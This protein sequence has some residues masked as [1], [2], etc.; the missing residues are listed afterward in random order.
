LRQSTQGILDG[1]QRRTAERQ[2]AGLPAIEGGIPFAI[3][4]PESFDLDELV[5]RFKLEVVSE[6]DVTAEGAHRY[7]LVA[8]QRIEDSSLLRLIDEFAQG[9]RGSAAVASMLEIIGSP[10]DPRRLD[11]ILGA[12]LAARWPFPASEEF[13]L[14]A[15]FQTRGMFVDLGE[16]P[17]KARAET[18]DQHD[19]RLGQWFEVQKNRCL[20]K[21]DDFTLQLEDELGR[22]VSA[23]GGEI[24]KQWENGAITATEAKVTF[25]DSISVRIRMSGQ[26]FCDLILNHPRIFEVREPDEVEPPKVHTETTGAGANDFR[27]LPPADRAPSVC[28]I[29]SGIQEGHRLLAAAIDGSRSVCHLPGRATNDTSDE[30]PGGGHGTRVAGAVVYPGGIPSTGSAAARCQLVN[31]RVLDAAC[32]LPK[33][34]I[35]HA[36]IEKIVGQNPDCRIFVQSINAKTPA[37]TRHVSA[38]AA[39]IDDLSYRYDTLFIVSSGNLPPHQD[40]PGKGYLDHLVDGASHPDYLLTDSAR[41]ATPA[42]SLQALTVGSQALTDFADGAWH[43]IAT[44]E[45][46]SCFSRSGLGIWDTVKPDVVEF[47]GDCCVPVGA[48]ATTAIQRADTSP[49]LVRSTLHGGPEAARDAVGTSFAAPKV[50]ALA[51]ELQALL[52]GQPMLLVRALIANA[53]R[54]PAWAEQLPLDERVKAFRWIG[55]GR[56]DWVRATR[57]EHTRVTLIT[58]GVMELRAGEAAVFEVP[59]PEELRTPG[60]EKR[61]RIDVTLSYASEPRRTRASLKGYQAVWL[62]WKA[63]R[64]RE[65]LDHFLHS[66]WKDAAAPATTSE[67]DTI[68]WM[69]SDREDTGESRAVRRQGT[70]Q[71]DWAEVSGF[72]LP[73][74]WAIAVRG[75]KGWNAADSNATARFALVVSIEACAPNVRVYEPV[76]VELERLHVQTRPR[77]QVPAARAG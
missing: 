73:E 74:S 24:V 37:P 26:G 66:M 42:Q 46:P 49:H 41:I 36:V 35:P 62:D 43:S 30:V 50:A 72:D 60:Q 25:P 40:V 65:P 54:W 56:P 5:E 55:Y 8:A 4:V 75:H 7:I 67:P 64:L 6:E 61:F 9:V 29:D 44:G 39:K 19:T 31:T 34:L 77:I 33:N 3:E 53:A 23:H 59:I 21:W 22:I 32:S 58:Q 63:S 13:L 17:R 1:Y 45:Q 51:A 38:W 16:R 10:D 28:V 47:G 48:P 11:S 2:A 15:S 76:R 14:D 20:A 18:K 68:R 52:P 27:L 12:H 69:L 71:K 70:L 57:N